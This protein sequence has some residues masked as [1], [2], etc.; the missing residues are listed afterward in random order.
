MTQGWGATSRPLRQRRSARRVY[1]LVGGSCAGLFLLFALLRGGVRRAD[2]PGGQLAAQPS[3]GLR[4]AVAAAGESFEDRLVHSI[5]TRGR[6]TVTVH[7]ALADLRRGG[8]PTRFGNGG[9]PTNNLCWGALYGIETHLVNRAGWRRAYADEGK[10]AG[11]VRRIVLH[12]SVQPSAAWMRRGIASP[13][14]AYVLAVAWPAAR[15]RDAMNAPIR[16]AAGANPVSLHVDG[17]DVEFG[18]GSVMVGYLGLNGMDDGY[19]DP[20][21]SA[22]AGGQRWQ[23]IGVFYVSSLSAVYLHRSVVEHGLY[24][25]LFT[26]QPIVPEAYTVAG[27]LDALLDGRIGDGFLERAADQYAEHQKQVSPA[28]AR[29]MFFR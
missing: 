8:R 25:V 10:D 23:P 9:D 11:A 2:A 12:R 20:F 16:D 3:L 13:F 22:A 14:D 6:L 29:R 7:V 18:S 26:R 19:W 28:R 5:R 27:I 1:L 24:P 17:E 4:Q 21:E 15:I